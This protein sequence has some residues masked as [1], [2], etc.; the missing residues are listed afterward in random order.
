MYSPRILAAVLLCTSSIASAQTPAFHRTDVASFDGARGVA[1]ADFDGNGWADVAQ[2]N[3]GR[4][5]VSIL[6]NIN[7]TLTHTA[8][9][10]VGTGPFAIAAADFNHDGRAD[11]AVA[12]ADGR[13]SGGSSR[14]CSSRGRSARRRSRSG[15]RRP[16]RASSQSA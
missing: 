3:N 7:G 14:S 5:N 8:G 4:N 12:N 11:L 1:V 9:I 10:P 6:L 13:R 15:T 2:A 16:A